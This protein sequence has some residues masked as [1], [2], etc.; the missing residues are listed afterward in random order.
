MQ[1]LTMSLIGALAVGSFLIFQDY[2]M[3][4][5]SNQFDFSSFFYLGSIVVIGSI[6]G[7]VILFI[8]R[9]IIKNN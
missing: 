9:K 1:T 7:F 3:M 2:D 5:P 8:K 4:P 6:I